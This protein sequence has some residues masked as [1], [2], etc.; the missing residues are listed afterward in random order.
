LPGIARS[1]SQLGHN[2][3]SFNRWLNLGG[4]WTFIALHGG[5]GLA[6]FMLRPYNALA[7]SAPIA[8]FVSV[9]LV[10][11]LGQS[12]WFLIPS[13][14]V[15]SPVEHDLPEF[16][17]TSLHGHRSQSFAIFRNYAAICS[18]MKFQIPYKLLFT[19]FMERSASVANIKCEEVKT[20]LPFF[21]RRSLANELYSLMYSIRW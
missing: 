20:Y 14:A 9:F 3:G 4:L 12:G 17:T 16:I 15:C 2:V 10:Y 13:V 11:P 6:G 21:A 18:N 7:F 8:V 19:H 5:L 1:L